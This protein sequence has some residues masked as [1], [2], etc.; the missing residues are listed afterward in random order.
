M[1]LKI[2]PLLPASIVTVVPTVP[3]I[4]N[5]LLIANSAFKLT[6]V[7][8]GANVI[9]PPAGVSAISCRSVPSDPSSNPLVTSW[10]YENVVV[11]IAQINAIRSVVFSLI[12]F[13]IGSY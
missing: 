5:S 8:E 9:V 6:V 2:L 11:N 13:D 12:L 1:T 3:F 10:P 4:V 7:T